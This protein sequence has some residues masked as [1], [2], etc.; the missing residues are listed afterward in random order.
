MEICIV[1]GARPNFI[2]VAPLIR[3]IDNLRR[4]GSPISYSLVYTGC[5]GDPTLEGTLFDDLSI[6]LPDEYLGVDCENLNELTGQVMSRFE[7]YLQ[8]H[9]TLSLIHI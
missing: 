8:Q 5:Q 2:K 4:E 6:H 9:P 1:S 7:V 3:Q